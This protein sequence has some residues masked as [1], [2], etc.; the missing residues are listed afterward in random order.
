MGQ[1]QSNILVDDDTPPLTLQ[2]RNVESVASY[3]KSGKVKRV[4]VMVCRITHG[5]FCL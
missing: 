4:V 1:E 3:V 5:L 2:R